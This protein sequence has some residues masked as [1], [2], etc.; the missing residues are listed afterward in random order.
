LNGDSW[1]AYESHSASRY[2][3]IASVDDLIKAETS[4]ENDAERNKA[5]PDIFESALARLHC[6][7]RGRILVVEDTP[8]DAEAG[9]EGGA[10][11]DRSALWRLVE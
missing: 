11:D 8:H 9:C 7:D 6:A 10:P 3:Q 2:K 4:S 1:T 5:F